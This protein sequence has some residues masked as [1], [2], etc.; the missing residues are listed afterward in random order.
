MYETNFDKSALLP[1]GYRGSGILLHVTSLPSRYGI[2]DLGDS[3]IQ[4]ID[5]LVSA[6]QSWWQILPLG[7]TGHGNSPYD[8]LSTFAGN[9]LLLSPER[10]AQ[11]GLVEADALAFPR[12][13]RNRVAFDDVRHFKARLL[14]GAWERY[15]Q[16]AFPELRNRFADFCEAQ[17]DWL[18]DF[19]QFLAFKRHFGGDFFCHWP[20]EV[21]RHEP[22]AVAR[23]AED[24]RERIEFVKFGQFLFFQQWEY[25]KSHAK[26]RGLRILGDLPI[27]VSHDS[28]EVWASPDLFLLDENRHPTVVAGVPP[29]YFSATGQRWGNP[30]YDW[31]RMRSTGYQWWLRRMRKL[32]ALVDGVRLDHFRA[33]AAAWHVPAEAPTAETGQWVTGPGA[34]FLAAAQEALDGLPLVAEDL[35]LITD[36][37]IELRDQF[38]LPG[39][40]V[41]QFAFDGDP[42]NLFLPHRYE[43]N[44]VAFTGTHDNDTTRGW[45][46]SLTEDTLRVVRSFFGPHIDDANITE[47][48][49][50][51]IWNSDSALSIVPLQDLLNLDSS[52][53][54]NVPGLAS[55]NWNWRVE[56]DQL[57]PNAFDQLA[58]WTADTGRW[59][60]VPALR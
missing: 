36:D 19:S 13:E 24:L 53:R 57:R 46:Q 58:Q 35:G 47:E 26:E 34:D 38:N 12:S 59:R 42:N 33:F 20:R 56:E 23:L 31:S 30:L 11:W 27:F 51:T 60:Q 10:L 8:P 21:A 22:T 15:Q 49:V 50:R 1:I 14:D 44:S 32:L 16:R 18:E 45:Y 55:G 48:M 3:A 25:V 7:P 40:K 43:P 37:V 17:A 2:G 41:L 52:A 4:W 9:L 5:R 39:M 28:A 29:D 54:M 6:G